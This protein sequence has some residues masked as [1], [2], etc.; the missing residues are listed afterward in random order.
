MCLYEAG[1]TVLCYE[2]KVDALSLQPSSLQILFGPLGG[3]QSSVGSSQGSSSGTTEA[4]E[5]SHET[6][7][8]GHYSN[9]EMS[10]ESE[11]E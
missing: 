8:S 2:D 7:D 6:G 1:K 3:L 9:E 10:N 4:S 5:G 11:I